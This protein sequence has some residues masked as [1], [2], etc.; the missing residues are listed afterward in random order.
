M[1]GFANTRVVLFP[2]NLFELP[3]PHGDSESFM[4]SEIER[5]ERYGQVGPLRRTH[6]V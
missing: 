3:M 1:A 4:G 6:K 2:F 5:T